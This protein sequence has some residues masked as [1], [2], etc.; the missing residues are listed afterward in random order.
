M[1]EKSRRK[2]RTYL[3]VAGAN[4][5]EGKE[6]ETFISRL[7]RQKKKG[8]YPVGGKRTTKKKGEDYSTSES[9]DD[10]SK[11][12]KTVRRGEKNPRNASGKLLYL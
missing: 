7:H 3:P 11:P 1:A 5:G 9:R 8:L 4:Q 10:D 2:R 12:P 6:G